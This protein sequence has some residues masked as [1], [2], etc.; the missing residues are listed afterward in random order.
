[1]NFK[2]PRKLKLTHSTIF[3]AINYGALGMVISHEISHGFDDTGRKFTVQ[4]INT[5]CLNLIYRLK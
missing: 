1:M 2:N 3:R 5:L 4:I